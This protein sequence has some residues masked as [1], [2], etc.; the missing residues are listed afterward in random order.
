MLK[1]LGVSGVL[2]AGGTHV[3]AAQEGGGSAGLARF[4]VGHF[5][6]DTPPVDVL[7]DDEPFPRLQGV[8][9]GVLS[10]Y[11]EVPAGTYNVKVVLTSD[12]SVVA[13]DEDLTLRRNRD[14]TV[15]ATDELDNITPVVLEDDNRPAPANKARIRVCQFSP[16]APTVDVAVADGQTLI[17]NLEFGDVTEYLTLDEGTYDV[18]VRD[19][20]SD[21]VLTESEGVEIDGGLTYSVFAL[22]YVD[23]PGEEFGVLAVVDAV[24]PARNDD[25]N[26]G[27]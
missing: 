11:F 5:S 17:S 4:R 15:A 23:E 14:Y 19:S 2:L 3:V 24:S 21:D 6:P 26:P 12:N 25:D 22:G 18:E 7:I 27:R 16:D 10:V 13:I 1:S 20:E 9:F 8:P